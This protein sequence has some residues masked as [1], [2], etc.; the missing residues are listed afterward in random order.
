MS[1]K[2]RVLSGGSRGGKS[3]GN[4]RNGYLGCYLCGR[5]VEEATEPC[6]E[7]HKH[8]WGICPL[9]NPAFADIP[10]HMY[11]IGSDFADESETEASE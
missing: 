3:A 11:V 8:I 1:E 7:G 9:P 5:P 4:W 6:A 2:I 10:A